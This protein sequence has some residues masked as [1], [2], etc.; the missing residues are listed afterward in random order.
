MQKKYK[1]AVIFGTFD[2]IH[3]GHIFLFNYTKNLAEKLYV[4]IAR[5]K[6]LNKQTLFKDT[7]R[8]KNISKYKIIDG[9]YLGSLTDP[10][11]FYK[12][13]EPDLVVLGYDQYKNVELLQK[14]KITTKRAPSYKEELFKSQKIRNIL[15]DNNAKFFL[16]DKEGDKTSFSIIS[17][18]RKILN[19][20]KVGFS[21]TL[22][23][24]ANGLMIVACGHAT[25]FLDAFHILNKVYKAKIEFGKVSDTYDAKGI[26]TLNNS[27]IIPTIKK[28]EDIIAKKFSGEILQAPP[29]FSAKKINGK[30]MYELA[31]KGKN[32]DIKKEKITINN[33]K[34]LKYKYP[35]LELEID[36]SKGTYIRSIANDLGE[37]LKTGAILTK[38][39]RTKIGPFGVIDSI[40]QATL[41]KAT[42]DKA[43]IN[44][45]D[46][47]DKINNSL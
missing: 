8:L 43:K 37:I 17:Q 25:K 1:K 22:D 6:N 9:V 7:Q 20:K 19:I 14:I 30:K 40:K 34:I 38:L 11:E 15:S 27:K 23:P 24:M 3:P 39:Q 46:I 31:R 45:L 26:V 10:L 21:G 28:I 36:C 44:I 47:V 42:L 4:I 16:I 5:D 33:I 2:I 18:I 35:F 29:I 13:L 12:N 41:D 32:I